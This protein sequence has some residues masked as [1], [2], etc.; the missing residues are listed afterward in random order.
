M[1][2]GDANPGSSGGELR[3]S[4]ASVNK[5]NILNSGIAGG[6]STKAK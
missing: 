4:K 3:S 5:G 1:G 6:S 2:G